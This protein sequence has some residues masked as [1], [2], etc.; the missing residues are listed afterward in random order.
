MRIS[1]RNSRRIKTFLDEEKLRAVTSKPILKEMLKEVFQA[2][3]KKDHR[4]IWNLRNEGR[5]T[6]MSS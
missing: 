6:E 4:E 2:E 3:R 5:A 1:F